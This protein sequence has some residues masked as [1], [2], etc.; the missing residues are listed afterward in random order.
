MS[1]MDRI[2]KTYVNAM[3]KQG[4]QT[5]DDT[6]PNSLSYSQKES[7]S[8]KDNEATPKSPITGGGATVQKKSSRVL[9]KQKSNSKLMKNKR[10]SEVAVNSIGWEVESG[11]GNMLHQFEMETSKNYSDG[12][13]GSGSSVVD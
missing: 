10:R 13:G 6:T 4:R 9:Q 5:V 1:Y 12:Q 11:K 8:H 7:S 2:N 3:K